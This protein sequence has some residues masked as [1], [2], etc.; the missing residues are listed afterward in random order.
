MDIAVNW[1]AGTPVGPLGGATGRAI[2]GAAGA[3]GKGV[4]VFP[5]VTLGA[6][7]FGTLEVFTGEEGIIVHLSEGVGPLVQQASGRKPRLEAASNSST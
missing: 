4:G 1:A 3:A 6:E 7:G 2:I 5:A